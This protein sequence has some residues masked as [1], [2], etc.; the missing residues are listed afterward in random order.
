MKTTADRETGKCEQSSDGQTKSGDP[1]DFWTNA[2][3][4]EGKD[5]W[6]KI[7]N[8]SF[9]PSGFFSPCYHSGKL[10]LHGQI[11]AY[12]LSN[13]ECRGI[14]VFFCAVFGPL[15]LFPV[16][17]LAKQSREAQAF[18]LG[19]Y[20]LVLPAWLEKWV[21]EPDSNLTVTSQ[22]LSF[23]DWLGIP[24]LFVSFESSSL[25][26][27]RASNLL[28]CNGRRYQLCSTVLWRRLLAQRLRWTIGASWLNTSLDLSSF[29][30]RMVGVRERVFSSDTKIS[31]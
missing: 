30:I 17:L 16:C 15:C 24:I 3:S 1:K 2:G 18:Q 5:R 31:I 8:W 19:W 4:S 13:V 9:S 23:P 25:W 7:S 22:F 28:I 6:Q 21:G 12:L 11:Y 26:R 29:P 10:T 14:C 27:K 20:F